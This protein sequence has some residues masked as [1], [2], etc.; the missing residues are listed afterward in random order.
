MQFF[1]ALFTST[2]IFK[3]IWKN[4]M[5]PF[6]QLFIYFSSNYFSIG[7]EIV[8]QGIAIAILILGTKF[9]AEKKMLL[10]L[11]VVLLA[12]QFHISAIVAIPLYFTTYKSISMKFA[13]VLLISSFIIRM[14][15]NAFV[16]ASLIVIG[17]LPFVPARIT[18][19][20][21]VYTS[22]NSK[23]GVFT[24]TNTGLGIIVLYMVY[25]FIVFLCYLNHKNKSKEIFLFNFLG[26]L[27]INAVGRNVSIIN[28]LSLYYFICGN[29]MFAYNALIERNRFYKKLDIMRILI[30]CVFLLFNILTFVSGF[31][32]V[33]PSGKSTAQYLIPYKTFLDLE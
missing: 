22:M 30:V 28:R 16:R 24:E 33:R 7:F 10:W 20:I 2:V 12:M 6:F 19:L 32:R 25:S 21:Y 18:N 11:A 29:G 5:F 8:R 4:G 27:L 15:G 17:M 3:N 13:V 31:N 9:I 23:H 1:L 14:F 26:Y